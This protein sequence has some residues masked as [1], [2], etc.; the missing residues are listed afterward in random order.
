M[1]NSLIDLLQPIM[2]NYSIHYYIR[3]L[4]HNVKMLISLSV[5]FLVMAL[6]F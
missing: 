2:D 5:G 1:A 3:F 4:S 6:I